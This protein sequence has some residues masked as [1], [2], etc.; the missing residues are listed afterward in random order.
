MIIIDYISSFTD[1]IN[2]SRMVATTAKCHKQSFNVTFNAES[3]NS[4]RYL[5]F[6]TVSKRILNAFSP[7][8]GQILKILKY[9]D[10]VITFN[11]SHSNKK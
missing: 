3:C 11:C 1:F 10:S 7:K 2:T 6:I 4:L 5:E 8:A 9:S